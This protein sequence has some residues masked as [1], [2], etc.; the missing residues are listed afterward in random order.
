MALG[1]AWEG[2]VATQ[3]GAWPGFVVTLLNTIIMGGVSMAIFFVIFLIIFPDRNKM[4]AKSKARLEAAKKSGVS[5][6]QLVKLEAKARDD[7]MRARYA[8]ADKANAKA[9]SQASGRA[10]SYMASLKG[11]EKAKADLEAAQAIGGAKLASAQLKYAV[12]E[13]RVPE[14]HQAVSDA[15]VAKEKAVI[16]YEAA[17]GSFE[18]YKQE[19]G[20]AK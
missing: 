15:A 16:E 10:M 14:K 20:L 9:K 3:L 6:E 8:N 7:E 12:A 4:A 11:Y 18:A 19:L 13:Q 1:S 17:L 5:G 2:L